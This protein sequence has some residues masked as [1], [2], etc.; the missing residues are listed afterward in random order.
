MKSDMYFIDLN[1]F[2]LSIPDM[3]RH[4]TITPILTETSGDIKICLCL[5]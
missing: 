5:V 3:T 4:I 1:I 2:N